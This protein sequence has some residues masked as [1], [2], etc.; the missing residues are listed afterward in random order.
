MKEWLNRV[1]FG[2]CIRSLNAMPE[3]FVHTCVTSPPY[4]GLRDY[5]SGRWEG[6]DASHDHTKE[7]GT[8]VIGRND[9]DRQS[10]TF[11]GQKK[12]ARA[13]RPNPRTS[14]TIGTHRDVSQ[15][16]ARD[17]QKIKRVAQCSCG[18]VYVDEQIGQ[19]QTPEE[20][21]ANMVNVFRAVR[22][23]LR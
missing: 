19:E 16:E 22:R 7:V 1:Y 18:A 15:L 10:E 11:H 9:G 14:P 4:F 2:D 8:R 5:G 12:T 3:K 17:V 21:V 23:V 6:G 13:M 20:Y